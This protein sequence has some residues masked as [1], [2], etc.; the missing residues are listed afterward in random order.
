MIKSEL[1]RRK[2][3]ANREK[4]EATFGNATTLAAYNLYHAYI[5]Y[6]KS[7]ID[8]TKDGLILDMHG[9]SHSEQWTEF[10]YVLPKWRITSDTYSSSARPSVCALIQRNCNSLSNSTCFRDLIRGNVSLGDR[11]NVAGYNSIPSDEFPLGGDSVYGYY[12]GGHVVKE[13]GSKACTSGLNV[14]A[15]QVEMPSSIRLFNE[16]HADYVEKLADAVKGFMD[17]FYPGWLV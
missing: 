12:T 15:I 11:L 2:L 5:D 8:P 1:Q 6:A 7:Q 3:D 17:D 14:D 16:T 10:G 13:H 9:Q 4:N